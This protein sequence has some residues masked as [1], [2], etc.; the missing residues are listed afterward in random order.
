MDVKRFRDVI[1]KRKDTHDE[2]SFG[3]EQCW[4]EEISLLTEDRHLL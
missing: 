1:K 4:N 2:Y 3:I